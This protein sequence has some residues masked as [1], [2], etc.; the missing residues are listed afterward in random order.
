MLLNELQKQVQAVEGLK[1]AAREVEVLKSHVADLLELNT[2]LARLEA[3]QAQRL[4]GVTDSGII[5][6]AMLE[7]N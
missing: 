7:V 5:R 1:A 4:M 6:I 2:R 3:M